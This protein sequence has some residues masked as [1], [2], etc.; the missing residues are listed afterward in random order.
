MKTEN[1]DLTICRLEESPFSYEDVMKLIHASVQ[2]RLDQNINFVVARMSADEY[3]EKTKNSI[4]VVAYRNNELL[5][6]ACTTILKDKNGCNFA[7]EEMMYVSPNSKRGGIG[8]KMQKKRIEIAKENGC[9][10]TISSTAEKALSSVKWHLKNGYNLVELRSYHNTNYY[11][12]KFRTQIEPDSKWS[13]P[14]YCK[15]KYW[16]SAIKCRIYFKENGEIRYPKLIKC[17]HKLRGV[18]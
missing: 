15:I 14:L 6:T 17:Y 16:Q 11:S 3:K 10:Y 7:A 1:N 8:S 4:V 18:S 2:E 12:K 9:A 5:G 13:N